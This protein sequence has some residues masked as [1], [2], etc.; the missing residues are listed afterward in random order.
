MEITLKPDC[1][2][3]LMADRHGN[4]AKTRWW[5]KYGNAVMK[6]YQIGGGESGLSRFTWKSAENHRFS[7][8]RH[9]K[10]PVFDGFLTH[11]WWFWPVRRG[12]IGIGPKTTQ[13]V[14]KK[15]HRPPKSILLEV[16]VLESPLGFGHS[17][18]NPGEFGV[19]GQ[20]S[21]FWPQNQYYPSARG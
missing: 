13:K 19:F 12:I 17:W 14:V 3:S 9:S 2:A 10:T 4:H 7:L 5:R 21:G 20:K 1:W 16:L 6:R 8:S 11:F 18:P 15:G